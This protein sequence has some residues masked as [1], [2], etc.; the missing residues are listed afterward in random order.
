MNKVN[1]VFK[2]LENLN[3]SPLIQI[4]WFDQPQILQRMLIRHLLI[5]TEP[6]SHIWH[7]FPKVLP[8][9]TVHRPRHD[10]RS[11]SRLKHM[12]LTF[13]LVEFLQGLKK[14]WLGTQTSQELKVIVHERSGYFFLSFL[15]PGVSRH[16]VVDW[17][18]DE[19]SEFDCLV[20]VYLE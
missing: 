11:R 5:R 3:P 15:D 20:V 7:P 12:R 8:V 19:V 14:P 9:R 18:P 16:S 2:I 6:L 17:F 10:E 13:I 1:N 4:I